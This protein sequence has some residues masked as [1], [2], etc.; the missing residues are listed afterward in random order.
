MESRHGTIHR[1]L[2]H[3]A[4]TMTPTPFPIASPAEPINIAAAL[5]R[6]APTMPTRDSTARDARDATS[7]P[8][9]KMA[10][11]SPN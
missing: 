11:T 9:V 3:R 6:N 7:P 4:Q 1:H 8:R 10:T 5:H 2:T